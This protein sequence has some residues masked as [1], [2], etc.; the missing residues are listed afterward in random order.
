VR[1]RNRLPICLDE[2][3]P[4]RAVLFTA[5]KPPPIVE[6][7]AFTSPGIA[8]HQ[9]RR[10]NQNQSPKCFHFQTTRRIK[11]NKCPV[12]VIALHRDEQADDLDTVFRGDAIY[13]RL[14][15]LSL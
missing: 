5:Q 6:Q 14:A 7:R 11:Q 4:F 1:Q 3:R 8:G 10:G 13:L 2:I 9:G 12:E 15:G